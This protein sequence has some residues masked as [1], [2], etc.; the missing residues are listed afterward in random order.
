MTTDKLIG[1]AGIR[2]ATIVFSVLCVTGVILSRY[3]FFSET[4][5][6]SLSLAIIS[7]ILAVVAAIY[8]V[9]P[10]FLLWMRFAKVLQVLVTTLLF[11]ACYIAVV[12]FF[13]FVIRLMDPLGQ[14]KQPEPRTFWLERRST[15]IDITS[16]QR[17]G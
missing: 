5:S 12:P 7:G 14:R 17:M 6:S 8:S 11:G 9:R 15:G 2:I 4:R 3:R 16:M 1:S 13:F 10:V